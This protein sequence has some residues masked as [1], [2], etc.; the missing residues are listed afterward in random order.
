MAYLQS[1]GCKSIVREDHHAL[2]VRSMMQKGQVDL[3]TLTEE[4]IMVICGVVAYLYIHFL[5]TGRKLCLQVEIY[6]HFGAFHT[7]LR[8]EL[9]LHS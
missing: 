3:W 2:E 7:P 5:I 6:T 8:T 1:T 4:T 9:T